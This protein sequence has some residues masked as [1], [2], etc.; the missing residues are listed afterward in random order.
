MTPDRILVVDDEPLNVEL[1]DQELSDLG[2]RVEKATNGQEA[3]TSV[4]ASP[5]DLILLDVLM[6]GIDGIEVCRRL[7]D[8]TTTR[9][10]PIVIMTASS[11][12]EDRLRGVEAGADDFLT[13]PV[14][15]RELHARIRSALRSKAAID[16]KLGELESATEQIEA[17]GAHDEDVTV[18]IASDTSTAGVTRF[19]EAI[20]ANDGTIATTSTSSSAGVFRDADPGTRLRSAVR[21]VLG[22]DERPMSFGIASGSWAPLGWAST[23]R[24]VG[25]SA[26]PVPPSPQQHAR[27]AAGR[28]VRSSS[29]RPRPPNSV[30]DPGSRL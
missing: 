19:L 24:L 25:W 16:E 3:L 2:Y 22:L 1:L 7:K 10:I 20:E 15:E 29:E 30:P 8:D 14:D 23:G 18:V 27:R 17:L 6:P 13:K 9:L 21:T 28:R 5:P 4:A 12:R 11:D 26:S